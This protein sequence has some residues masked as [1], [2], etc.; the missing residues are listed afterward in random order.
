MDV[1]G[2]W[3]REDASRERVR[4]LPEWLQLFTEELTGGA[5]SSESG[6]RIEPVVGSI[7]TPRG[8]LPRPHSSPKPFQISR[9]GNTVYSRIFA[10]DPNCEVCQR[11]EATRAPCRRSLESQVDRIPHAKTLR[12]LYQR[13]SDYRNGYRVSYPCKKKMHNIP[14]EVYVYSYFQKQIPQLFAPR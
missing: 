3:F 6:P 13:K 7:P 1:P 2:S 11:T 9:V 12:I 10:K 4:D 8:E 5:S 14:R